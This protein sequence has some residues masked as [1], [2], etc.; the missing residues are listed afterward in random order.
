MS[1]PAG[2]TGENP[3]R[4]RRRE[5]QKNSCPSYPKPQ[6]GDRSLERSEKADAQSAKSKYPAGKLPEPMTASAGRAGKQKIYCKENAMMK[7]KQMKKMLASILCMVLIAALALIA[8]G[9]GGSAAGTAA[10]AADTQVQA[11][12]SGYERLGE[13]KTSFFFTVTDGDGKETAFEIH[14]EKST[15]GEALQECGLIEG[16]Q[17][18]YGLYVKTVNGITADYDADGVYWAFYIDGKYAE[19]GADTTEISEGASYAF[20]IEKA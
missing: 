4:A 15:V 13:G 9:C 20:K 5:A 19:T 2:E 8:A 1:L 3:V 18:E 16:E 10:A 17:S 11:Q 6:F 12:A 14:T 7:M